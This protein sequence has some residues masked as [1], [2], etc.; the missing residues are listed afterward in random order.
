MRT[1]MTNDQRSPV[2]GVRLI[3]Y[4]L[5]TKKKLFGWGV[6]DVHTGPIAGFRWNTLGLDFNRRSVRSDERHR[7]KTPMSAAFGE[8]GRL[9]PISSLRLH[10][11]TLS[12]AVEGKESLQLTP[13]PTYY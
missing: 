1:K 9:S 7:K 3:K 13:R 8:R 11:N 4:L 6:Y 5:H 2:E 10:K 12:W